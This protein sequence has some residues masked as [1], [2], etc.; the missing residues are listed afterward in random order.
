MAFAPLAAL[1]LIVVAATLALT[2]P[3]PRD[4]ISRGLIGRPAPAYAFASLRDGPPIEP[5][6]FRGRA[7][8][9]NFFAS[10]CAPCRVEHPILMQLKSDGVAILGV[11]YKDPAPRAAALLQD[12]GD[13]FMAVGLDPDGRYGLEIGLAGVPETF[14]VGADGRI[15]A[16]IRGPLDEEV[17][18]TRILPALR[19][20]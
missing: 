10:W 4:T 20:E 11:A 9:I 18:R 17:V 19:E 16:L 8:L 7:Y 12:L 2:Q 3:G 13:P 6:A 5:S 14:V 15:R 1:A